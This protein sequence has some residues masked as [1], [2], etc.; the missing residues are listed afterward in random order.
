LNLILLEHLDCHS[1]LSFHETLS[2]L[3]SF[4]K[5]ITDRQRAENVLFR[6]Y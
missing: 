6:T 5:V 4:P 2:I 1:F 3:P